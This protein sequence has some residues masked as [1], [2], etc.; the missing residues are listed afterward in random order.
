MAIAT[1]TAHTR[2]DKANKIRKEGF[3]P[4]V[5]YG[6]GH[7][8]G[9]SVQFNSSE[10]MAVIRR[11]GANARLNVA[12]GG[13]NEYGAIKDVQRHPVTGEVRHIDIQVFNKE[14][15]VKLTV[16]IIFEGTEDL[17][18]KRFVVGTL[19]TEIE[20]TGPAMEIPQSIT[21]DLSKKVAGD[22]VTVADLGINEDL[23]L[24]AEL[25]DALVTITE[26]TEEPEEVEEEVTEEPEVI[27]QSTE[28]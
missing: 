1:L 3:M 7:E 24:S 4:A 25:T 27:E 22:V 20:I 2:N 19:L 8:E 11:Y 26:A 9:S 13:K 15:V 16:P 28:E 12:I 10:L 5:V 21:M 14:D 18:A 23:R 17:A 6:F